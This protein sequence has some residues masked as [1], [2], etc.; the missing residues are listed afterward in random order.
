MIVKT[1]CETNGSFATLVSIKDPVE[2]RPHLQVAL[3]QSADDDAGLGAGHPP[4]HLQRGRGHQ[5][6]GQPQQ[7]P[8][9][10]RPPPPARVRPRPQPDA[11]A[12]GL[13]R[14]PPLQRPQPTGGQPGGAS[15]EQQTFSSLFICHLF[16][17]FWSVFRPFCVW[18]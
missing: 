5:G 1:D 14:I 11:G 4:L 6:A 18:I 15:L 12:G 2:N 10:L 8:A 9:G 3:F 16:M 13:H 17:I 7:P